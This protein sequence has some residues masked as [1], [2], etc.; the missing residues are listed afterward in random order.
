[1]TNSEKSFREVACFEE[2]VSLEVSLDDKYDGEANWMKLTF[3]DTSDLPSSGYCFDEELSEFEPKSISGTEKVTIASQV[4][5][6]LIAN[7]YDVEPITGNSD[8]KEEQYPEK[9]E[10]YNPDIDLSVVSH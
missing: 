3:I 6:L 4:R 1:M 9:H 10:P 2:T 5:S 7:G 8:T